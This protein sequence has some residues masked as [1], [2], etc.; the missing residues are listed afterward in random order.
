MSKLRVLFLIGSLRAGGSERQIVNILRFLDRSR[1]TP[2]LYLIAR[3]GEMLAEVP[4]DVRIAAWSERR[5]HDRIYVP[6]GTQFR[7]ARDISRVLRDE[8]V[9]V[10]YDRTWQM[11]LL[12]GAASRRARTGR[13]SAAVSDPRLALEHSHERFQLLKRAL[14]RRSYRRADYVAAASQGVR[15]AVV[16]YFGLEPQRVRVVRNIIDLQRI[17]SFSQ[18]KGPQLEPDRFHVIFAGRLGREKGPQ[19]LLQATDELVNRRGHRS[20]CV[21]LL[22]DGP[23]R[24][25][26]ESHARDAGLQRHVQFEGYQANPYSW[27]TRAQLFCLPSLYEGMPNALIEAL[28]CGLPA[29][30]ADCPHGPAEILDNGRLGC[31]VPPADAAALA[32]AIE[33][34]LEN[35]PRWKARAETARS[36]VEENFSPQAAVA[37]LQE[38][39]LSTAKR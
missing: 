5:G 13:I 29:V 28:A 36:F 18:A 15:D 37:N 26:L 34:A 22:G 38:L 11:T 4:E 24:A 19:Y 16:R 25:E 20:L 31:L 9:D 30:A 32:D 2:L 7:Q 10:L 17:Q 23:L 35:G 27:M 1:F 21:H 8:R 33:D 3:E 6:G 14:L 12:A 39:L